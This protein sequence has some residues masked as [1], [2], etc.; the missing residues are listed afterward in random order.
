MVV[1]GE[2]T[3]FPKG[4]ELSLSRAGMKMLVFCKAHQLHEKKQILINTVPKSLFFCLASFFFFLSLCL[5]LSLSFDMA[6]IGTGME[7]VLC[8]H[9]RIL[10]Y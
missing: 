1:V 3:W 10:I 4:A 6:H 5:S 7:S 9:R 8:A 2:R